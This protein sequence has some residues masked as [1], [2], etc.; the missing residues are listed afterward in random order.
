MLGISLASA[1]R[2]GWVKALPGGP[3]AVLTVLIS[4]C[5]VIMG[6]GAFVTGFWGLAIVLT[7][8]VVHSVAQGI[9]DP[10]MRR[11]INAL[12]NGPVRAPTMAI[13]TMLGNITFAIVAPIYGWSVE[14]YGHPTTMVVVGTVVFFLAGTMAI[15]I[16]RR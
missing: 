6:L 1:L 12:S 15:L 5:F 14:S 9:Y 11:E 13:A 2:L 3:W 8:F 16:Q 10:I 7:G 4:S